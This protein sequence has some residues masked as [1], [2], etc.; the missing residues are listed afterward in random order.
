MFGWFK[1]KDIQ[2]EAEDNSYQ[3]EVDLSNFNVVADFMY[4]ECGITDLDKRVLSF[5]RLKQFAKE[6]NIKNTND[7]L[8]LLKQKGDIYHQALNIV[9]VNETYFFREKKELDY[10]VQYIKNSPN[11]LKILSLPCSS[12]EEIYSI[13]IMMLIEG[14]ELSKVEITGYDIDFQMIQKAKEAIYDEHS[15]HNLPT[16]IKD[17]Y[18]DKVSDTKYGIKSFIKNGVIFQ[19]E[20]VFDLSNSTKKFDIVLSRN[21]MIYFDEQK[22]QKA[23]SII[24][25]LLVMDGLFIKGHADSIKPIDSL[26]NI[27]FG[28]Y[29]KV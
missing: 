16:H 20:N 12:G 7:F 15:L 26:K 29:K 10:L 9:T 4:K 22:R 1:K 28:I 5:S 17:E 23:L 14:I 27:A 21:M 8:D 18:L 3:D 25:E 13:L 11:R 6:Q 19:Q 2:K 24:S